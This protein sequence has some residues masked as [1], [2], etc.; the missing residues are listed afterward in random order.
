MRSL[1]RSLPV[2]VILAPVAALT[3]SCGGGSELVIAVATSVRDT[4][5]I[6]ELVRDFKE[7]NPDVGAVKPV[8]A[9]SGQLME[10]ARRGEVDVIISHWPEGETRLIAEDQ[11]IDRRP[12]MHN[13]FVVVGPADDPARVAAAASPTEAFRLIAEEEAA[14]ISR[15]DRSGTHVRELAIWEEAGIDPAGRSWYQ[16]SGAGQGASLLVASDKGA[17]TLVD[18]GTWAVLEERTELT[19]QVMDS[20]VPNLYSVTRVNPDKHDVN[21]EAALAFADFL[22]SPTGQA[23]VDEFGRQEYGE[24]LFVPGAPARN[25]TPTPVSTP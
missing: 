4:G 15:G 19:L 6:D 13:F 12:F 17:Y 5:L 24:S 7:Q 8:G 22:V 3:M 20:E 14:F 1:C 18:T 23:G 21:E 9:S 10:L 25:V 11:A 2:A 16:E